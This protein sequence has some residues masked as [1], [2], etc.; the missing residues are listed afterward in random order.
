MNENNKIKI[1]NLI[2]LDKSCSMGVI[3]NAAVDGFNDV[4][5]GIRVAQAESELQEHY[6]KKNTY[7]TVFL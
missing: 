6:V 2:I 3:R 1:F 7:T 5:E 4:L